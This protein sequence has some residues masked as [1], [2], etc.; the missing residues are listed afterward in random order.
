ME[1]PYCSKPLPLGGAFVQG[2]ACRDV[3]SR[4]EINKSPLPNALFIAAHAGGDLLYIFC[5]TICTITC[6]M[7]AAALAA[8]ATVSSDFSRQASASATISAAVAE[9]IEPAE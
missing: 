3:Q 4:D 2:R 6:A 1:K 7:S 9:G 5:Q 8:T